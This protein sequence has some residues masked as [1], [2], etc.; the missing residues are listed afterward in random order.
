MSV[1]DLNSTRIMIPQRRVNEED[2]RVYDEQVTKLIQDLVFEIK[3]LEVR[4]A[5]LE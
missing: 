5:A 4:V 1:E 2:L 3:A